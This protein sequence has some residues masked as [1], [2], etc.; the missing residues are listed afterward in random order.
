MKVL[1]GRE[2]NV[3]ER[4]QLLEQVGNFSI[5]PASLLKKILRQQ[6][7]KYESQRKIEG[8]ESQ[9]TAGEEEKREIIIG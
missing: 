1:E 9:N 4:W 3:E 2:Q 5:T 6:D 8:K 7:I